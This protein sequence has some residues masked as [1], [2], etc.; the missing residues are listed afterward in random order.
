MN[1]PAKRLECVELA[2]AF[3]APGLMT[4]PASWT[5]SKRFAQFGCGLAALRPCVGSAA[6]CRFKPLRRLDARAARV[7]RV[8]H[9]RRA[10][11]DAKYRTKPLGMVRV[12]QSGLIMKSRGMRYELPPASPCRR[13]PAGHTANAAS[14]PAGAPTCSRLWIPGVT[15]GHPGF[16]VPQSRRQGRAPA[17]AAGSVP[18]A[19]SFR[20]FHGPSTFFAFYLTESRVFCNH[21]QPF[22][23]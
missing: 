6:F 9:P 3:A 4:A 7:L 21:H 20:L 12:K 23:G 10:A 8:V 5:H 1:C 11:A 19:S 18:G 13:E 14:C 15:S 16:E 22:A 17:A 2:P